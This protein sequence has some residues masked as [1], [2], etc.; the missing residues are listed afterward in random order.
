MENKIEV[1]L[2]GSGIARFTLVKV[3]GQGKVRDLIEAAKEKGLKVE[4]GQTPMVWV[5]NQEEPLNLDMSLEAAGIQPHSRVQ[6]H[7]C[8]RIH[9]TVNFQSR[10]EQHPFSP[11]TILRAVKQWAAKKFDLSDLDAG[12]YALE[13]VGSKDRPAEDTQLGS[14]VQSGQCQIGFNLIPKQRVEG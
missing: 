13:L 3:P 11:S 6:I 14:L 10:S 9:V 2:Q 1:F 4:D 7:T 12:E 5:E 8:P